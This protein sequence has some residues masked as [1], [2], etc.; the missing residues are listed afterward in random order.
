MGGIPSVL[1]RIGF[2]RNLRARLIAQMGS[3]AISVQVMGRFVARRCQRQGHKAEHD[4][5]A[6]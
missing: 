5:A 1:S 2:S 6:G 4:D 3:P